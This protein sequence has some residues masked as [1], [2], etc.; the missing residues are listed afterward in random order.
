LTLSPLATKPVE[1]LEPLSAHALRRF[2][3]AYGVLPDQ[4]IAAYLRAYARI[5]L[6]GEG[7]TPRAMA[8][9]LLCQA[10]VFHSPED[11]RIAIVTDHGT[12]SSWDWVKWLPHAL[13]P[14]E[15]DGAGPLRLV[16]DGVAKLEQLLGPEFA[17]RA[18]FDPD[19]SPSREEPYT[20]VV[21]D[22]GSVPEASRIAT[23]GYRNATFVDVRASLPWK[24]ER[25]TLRLRLTPDSIVMVENDRSG[26][27][28]T[29]ELGH[30]DGMMVSSAGTLARL[31]APYRIGTTADSTEP[32]AGDFELAT[33]LGIP[34][35]FAHDV[36][37][38]W[39][40][41]GEDAGDRLRVPLGFTADGSPLVLDIKESAEGGMG[42][43]GLL[44]GATGS[45]KSE[46]L[47][48][49][50]LG[51][52][53]T[54]SSEALNFVLVDFKGGATFLG[55]DQLPHTSAVI[56][57]LA[58]EAALVT[59]MQDALQGELVRRQE[60]L[61]SAGNFRSALDYE[62]ARSK[63]ADL[64]PLPSL[65]VVVDEFSELLSAH[66]EFMDLFIMI[67]RLGRSL[68][69]HLLL[70]SQRLDEGR[71]GQ[72]ESHLSYRIGLRTFSAMESRGV[73]GVPDAYQLPS[74]P[75]NGFLKT[76]TTTLTRFKSAYVSGPYRR[77]TRQA[78]QEAVAG[79][80]VRYD[81]DYTAP[82]V[83]ASHLAEP[84]EV[85]EPVEERA[86]ESLLNVAVE[87]LR[88]AGGLPARRVWLPPL[89]VPPTL[90]ALLP[91]LVPDP[92]RGLMASGDEPGSN[93][94][95]GALKVPVGLVDRPFDQR[96][97]LLMADLSGAGGHI[98]IAG[99]PQ[100]G[101]STLVRTLMISLALTHTPEEVQFYCL[102]F[103]GGTLTGLSGLPHVGGLAG[104]LDP[105]RVHRAMV[106]ITSLIA[107]RERLFAD[108]GIDSMA[109][110]RQRRAAGEPLDDR[111]GDVFLVLD[112]WGTVRQDYPDMIPVLAQIAVRGLGFGVHLVVTSAR[113]GEIQSAVRDQLGSRFELALG[114]PV[115]S[116]INMRAA[117]TVPRIPGRGLTAERLHFMTA[118]PRLDGNGDG[119]TMAP[120]IAE[121]VSLIAE[122]WPGHAAPAV[123]ML[124]VSLDG[125]TMP[126]PEGDLKVPL[127]VEENELAPFW[128]DFEQSPHLVVV[129]DAETGKTNLL[130]LVARA[131]TA[132]YTPEQARVAIVDFRREL[133][134]VISA[135]SR[136]GY[137]VS[138]DTVRDIVNGTARAMEARRPGPD[139]SP[140]QLRRRD[141]WQ[142]PQLFLI[143][144]DYD[145][146]G[147][148]PMDSPFAPLLDF[149]NQGTELGLHLIV[150]RSANGASRSM[151]SDPLLR[152]LLEVNTPALQLSCPPSEGQIFGSVKPRQ[153]PPGRALHITRR[154]TLQIQTALAPEQQS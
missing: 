130:T 9:S 154:G 96:H 125:S 58:D 134:D 50:V 153:L 54:H 11:L 116:M 48:T 90:D 140:A 143:V 136:L 37:R 22:V 126:A 46:L 15:T 26:V 147:S 104:R 127:G 98:G 133:F 79:Q 71:M 25:G 108:Q 28:T 122:A 27:E 106:E 111:H 80:I 138:V 61:R 119:A 1:D 10:A 31:L 101:K 32:L 139:V 63:G 5:V 43:H 49:L 150:A 76:D 131:I 52:A 45:G 14:T 75:G 8:R 19:A 84:E 20:I 128:H 87:R 103:G 33:M 24:P 73:L 21:L 86:P 42:P 149:L 78:A 4:P 34:D 56:T 68:G 117:A 97:D 67:G 102:D 107:R 99:G 74:Q 16:T 123:R 44:I 88:E 92:L 62:Q 120:A 152:R 66:R 39:K 85:L 41:H 137:A 135:E 82:R 29:T 47:R 40:R 121:T 146:V 129:G 100:S 132:H 6:Q 18:P 112:G 3:R 55:L 77:K 144:D 30:P 93:R 95:L 70:A 17:G 12:R 148:N 142:G 118:L 38:L 69:V 145:M 151:S 89:N 36:T 72:L 110:F 83:S 94:Y 13:H 91:P 114:D 2:I 60:L 81:T 64:A 141:W 115:D 23:E 57:N 59:R 65:F 7:D 124:P 105:E 109:T 53:L 51:L 113:W 35:M